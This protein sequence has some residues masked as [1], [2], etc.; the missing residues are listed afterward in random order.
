MGVK[1]Q[2]AS[3]HKIKTIPRLWNILVFAVVFCSGELL[4]AGLTIKGWSLVGLCASL[5]PLFPGF[6][7]PDL[8]SFGWASCG[9][10]GALREKTNAL[11]ILKNQLEG[12]LSNVWPDQA[13]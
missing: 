5:V 2:P 9:S 1:P 10:C 11:H 7:G 3:A 13:H 6:L 8:S 4:L 12:S